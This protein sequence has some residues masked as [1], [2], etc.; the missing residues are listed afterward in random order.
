M[1]GMREKILNLL[2]VLIAAGAVLGNI[3]YSV[4][5]LRY[6]D[7]DKTQT[8]VNRL[9]VVKEDLPPGGKVGY[10]PD[11]STSVITFRELFEDRYPVIQAQLALVPVT[12]TFEKYSELV[13]FDIQ[14]GRATRLLFRKD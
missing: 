4:D 9:E 8:L 12:L 3:A 6:P 2:I 5:N 14:P 10:V 7:E 11:F 1:P 13:V